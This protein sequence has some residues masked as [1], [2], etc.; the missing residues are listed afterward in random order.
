MSSS[1]G[2][3]EPT[4]DEFNSFVNLVDIMT[5]SKLKGS[6][7]HQPSQQGS[8]LNALGADA[9]IT[10]DEFASIPPD[11]F[12]H[13]LQDTWYYSES[14]AADDGLS[15]DPT[16]RPPAIVKARARSAHHAARLWIGAEDTRA[17]K[18]RRLNDEA[19]YRAKKLLAM[20]STA[21]TA[22]AVQSLEGA[23]TV[24]ICE[25]ADTT[26]K[27]EVLVM[28]MPEYHTLYRNFKKW[29]LVDPK[30]EAT[31]TPVQLS[32][33]RAIINSG[34]SYVDLALW[35]GHQGR[36]A[37]A[38]RC[39]GLIPG[40][41]GTQVRADFKGPPDFSTWKQCFTVYYVAMVM[42]EQVSPPW[43]LAYI[44]M[45]AEYDSLYSHRNW[46]FLYQTDVRF[47]SEHMPAM[48]M[49]ESD[50]LE[51]AM[52]RQQT[53]EYNADKPWE[54]LW[55][56]AADDSGSQESFWWYREFERKSSIP[57][58]H[59][60]SRNIDGDARV[61]ASIHDH[62]ATSHNATN[63]AEHRGDTGGG[64]GGGGGKRRNNNGGGNGGGGGGVPKA[65]PP[66]A[67]PAIL[68]SPMTKTTGKKPK[69]ICHGYNTGACKGHDGQACPANPRL[70]H[71]CHWCG[72]S[73]TALK[74]RNPGTGA[75]VVNGKGGKGGKG[76]G[77]KDER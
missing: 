71:L 19:E 61:A 40:P 12:E 60:G 27:R 58:A 55:K 33:L 3:R 44:D 38:M 53:T 14:V 18:C 68:N 52:K 67:Q 63:T 56:L 4:A 35:G 31:P 32:V 28:P 20:Q 73:H 8:L 36:S 62:F 51:E 15:V 46:A 54:Y 26:M 30:P 59:A 65:L 57:D 10:I 39:E 64:N 76:K 77:G 74:C 43:L 42:L 37:R 50:R 47:R 34:T 25:V 48:A 66:A 41:K 45:I 2:V 5:W 6:M 22:A 29:A 16:I 17:T 11:E 23:Q 49:R 70:R 75:P 24:P 21:N 72:Q 69:Q 9:D 1:S 7:D 13:I